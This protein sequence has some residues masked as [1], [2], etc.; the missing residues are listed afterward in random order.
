M[1][2]IAIEFQSAIFLNVGIS[3]T[4]VALL[5][6]GATLYSMWPN[7]HKLNSAQ[8]LQ[9]KVSYVATTFG[10]FNAL[11]LVGVIAFSDPGRIV[12]LSPQQKLLMDHLGGKWQF[13]FDKTLELREAR[14][15]T[16][17]E[18]DRLKQ[19]WSGKSAIGQMHEDLVLNQNVAIGLGT[20]QSEYRFFQ[21]HR[22]GDT[23]CGRALYHE[24]RFDYG[25]MSHC[26]VRMN[27]KDDY[28][29][30]QFR[31]EEG[32][33]NVLDPKFIADVRKPV[34]TPGDCNADDLPSSR[35]SDWE[36]YVFRRE[37]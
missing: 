30:I 6:G 22:H 12:P 15:A 34:G 16:K 27:I 5:F 17:T 1:L 4:F 24:D 26:Y 29:F 21:M 35:W 23:V 9:F 8:L 32:I 28:L 13:D 3:V 14:G 2:A 25:D 33:P 37:K 19:M 20:P 11:L 10:T 36:L 7:R 31:F 18:I